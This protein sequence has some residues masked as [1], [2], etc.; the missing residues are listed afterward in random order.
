MATD[1]EK[2]YHSSSVSNKICN[3]LYIARC[4][5]AAVD[6][7]EIKSS[8]N[9]QI[10]SHRLSWGLRHALHSARLKCVRNSTKV[11][12]VLEP[13]QIQRQALEILF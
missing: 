3:T 5:P 2:I 10:L 11:H 12:F 9:K 7:T 1:C 4:L 8:H 6:V 13:K